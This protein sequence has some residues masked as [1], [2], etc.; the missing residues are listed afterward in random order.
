MTRIRTHSLSVTDVEQETYAYKN[1][2][3]ELRKELQ[4]LR[5]NETAALKGESESISRE[6]ESLNHKLAEKI[7][8]LKADVSMDLNNHKA[9]GR[10]VGT[11]GD[12]K[13]QMHRVQPPQG[14]IGV[15]GGSPWY[16]S[17]TQQQQI[18]SKSIKSMARSVSNMYDS[19]SR[20]PQNLRRSLDKFFQKAKPSDTTFGVIQKYTHNLKEAII[21]TQNLLFRELQALIGSLGTW[22]AETGSLSEEIDSFKQLSE[23]ALELRELALKIQEKSN[24][25]DVKDN[26]STSSRSKKKNNKEK[27]RSTLLPLIEQSDALIILIEKWLKVMWTFKQQI[28]EQLDAGENRVM[29]EIWSKC[30]TEQHL[31]FSTKKAKNLRGSFGSVEENCIGELVASAEA[32]ALKEKI[33]KSLK[34]F[35]MLSSA[36][37]AALNLDNDW[38]TIKSIEQTLGSFTLIGDKDEIF[39]MLNRPATDSSFFASFGPKV[40]FR[41]SYEHLDYKETKLNGRRRKVLTP[42]GENLELIVIDDTLV[43]IKGKESHKKL[44]HYPLAIQNSEVRENKHNKCLELLVNN[45]VILNF[46]SKAKPENRDR[47]NSQLMTVLASIA[48]GVRGTDEDVSL[49]ERLESGNLIDIDYNSE[50][51]IIPDMTENEISEKSKILEDDTKVSENMGQKVDSKVSLVLEENESDKPTLTL[52]STKSCMPILVNLSETKVTQTRFAMCSFTVKTTVENHWIELRDSNSN[53]RVAIA[54]LCTLSEAR[55]SPIDSHTIVMLVTVANETKYLKVKMA[56][57]ED[58]KKASATIFELVK[59]EARKVRDVLVEAKKNS[60]VKRNSAARVERSIEDNTTDAKFLL[61]GACRFDNAKIT[62]VDNSEIQTGQ[63]IVSIVDIRPHDALIKPEKFLC[64][65]SQM[66]WEVTFVYVPLKEF[67][68][69]KNRDNVNFFEGE[70]LRALAALT[71]SDNVDLQRSAALAFVEITEKDVKPVD[72]DT[73]EMGVCL[74]CSSDVEVQRAAAAA[75]GNLAVDIQNQVLIVNSGALEP[76]VRLMQSNNPEVQCNAV[77]CITNLATNDENKAKIAGS[78]ALIPLTKLAKSKDL[79]VQRNATGALLNMTHTV[80]N[81]QQLVNNAAIPVLVSLLSSPDYDVQYYSTTSL[82]NIAVDATHRKRLAASEPSLVPCLLRLT[83]S[84]SLKVQCQA[85]LALRNLA[86]DDKFQLDIVA[87]N[88]LQ[89]LLNKLTQ[90]KVP[91]ILLAAVACIRNI[92]IH[93]SNETPIVQS[94]FLPP[95]LELLSY[96]NEEIQ[97]HAMSTIRNLVSTDENKQA[98]VD[99]GAIEKIG[100]LL[101]LPSISIAVQSE[102]TACLAVLA[103]M[104]NV[105]PVILKLLRPLLRHT[106]SPSID[107]KANSAA[108]IGNLASKVDN[109]GVSAFIKE[110]NDVRRYLYEFAMSDDPTLQHIAVWTL[111]QFVSNDDRLKQK[112]ISDAE[113]IELVRRLSDK[114]GQEATS[115]KV[116]GYHRFGR[117]GNADQG[118]TPVKFHRCRFVEHTPSSINAMAFS[119]LVPQQSRQQAKKPNDNGASQQTSSNSRQGVVSGKVYLACARGNGDIE[120]WNPIRWHLE[121][122]IPGVPGTTIESVVWTWS[123]EE[124]QDDDDEDSDSEDVAE[125]SKPTINKNKPTPHG[126]PRLFTAGLDGC[127]TEWNISTLAPYSKVESGGGAIWCMAASPKGDELAIGCE[128]GCLRVFSIGKSC[129]DAI[130]YKGTYDRQ[131][132]RILSVAYHPTH[133]KLATGSSDSCI[134]TYSTDTYRCISRSTVDTVAKEET[135]VWAVVYLPNGSLVSGDSLGAVTFW[136]ETGTMK[137]RLKAHT[138]DVLCLSAGMKGDVVYSSGIDRKVVQYRLV[139]AQKSHASGRK[140]SKQGGKH[141][142]IS[143]ERRFH[144]HDVRALALCELKPI[145]ALVSGGV[146]TTLT[147]STEASKFPACKQLRHNSFPQKPLITLAQEARLV[148]YRDSTSVKVWSLGSPLPSMQPLETMKIG[149]KVEIGKKDKLVADIK[150]NC[151]TNL[152]AASISSN[153]SLIAVSDLQTT[154]LFKL[155]LPTTIEG[156][157]YVKRKIPA[158]IVRIK[159]VV[160]SQ[161]P[162]SLALAFTPDSGRLVAAGSDGVVRVIDVSRVLLDPRE[163]V[164]IIA[165]FAQNSDNVTAADPENDAMTLDNTST[166]RMKRKELVCTLSVSADGQWLATGDFGNQIKIYNMDALKYHATLPRFTYLHTSINF[167]AISPI[168]TVTSAGNEIYI[169]DVEKKCLSDWSR[170]Y[171]HRLPDRFVSRGE[172]IMGSDTSVSRPG[173]LVVYAANY[174][175]TIDLEQ[176]MGPKDALITVNKRKY[177]DSRSTSNSKNSKDNSKS[178]SAPNHQSAGSKRKQ[179]NGVVEKDGVIEIDSDSEDEEEVMH[180]AGGETQI[181]AFCMNHKYG[182]LMF[183]G[184]LGTE[185]AVAVERPILSVM[186]ALPPGYY[187]KRYGS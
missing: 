51:E 46:R 118:L 177:G 186:E 36:V 74:L 142:I 95:L 106:M 79:R 127:I 99:A 166:Q 52:F 29:K 33:D 155:T 37:L 180:P 27:Q 49:K 11:K 113:L 1:H 60:E 28:F 34:R 9:E 145:D 12:L 94:G 138:A 103:L 8:G 114:Q 109:G 179:P 56:S 136:T 10:D 72:R 16:A 107:V 54:K 174:I 66:S 2:L 48:A 82:S 132:G 15:V 162:G 102:M 23:V 68:L 81:R 91:Q 39:L 140:G 161:L 58:V 86:S 59:V 30:T 128:D 62:M 152:T 61:G 129:G 26:A 111:I 47:M 175:C 85:I 135:L 165:T 157:N 147:V 14:S 176:P 131:E 97:C 159:S 92:S 134:R 6:I 137:K 110:W 4:Q 57:E 126:T 139:T 156:P 35:S 43:L 31:I 98:V 178:K 163:R 120:L 119:P 71:Y 160:L 116:E 63:V 22:I 19:I 149:D 173:K 20:A 148:L 13:I 25:G 76:L 170:E 172:I 185:E 150:L 53:K 158:Q 32:D 70:P 42:T 44:A 164:D 183:F 112:V 133:K 130:V 169:Y 89:P 45:T 187:R 64:V 182:P 171:S 100:G 117:Q 96:D 88:G 40:Y 115:A 121:K 50:P 77:G 90:S 101:R 24:G 181:S 124:D 184:F 153:G 38:A 18:Q 93:P 21:D 41:C 167:H 104:D 144:S 168:L 3:Q 146:D 84:P 122:T 75:I 143:G 87:E 105:K 125:K 80:E 83:D 78:G 17:G 5:Q 151:A 141:F 123:V 7:A 154:R 55:R 67:E 73:I 65:M 69:E 108:A